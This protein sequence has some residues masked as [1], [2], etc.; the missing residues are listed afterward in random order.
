MYYDKVLVDILYIVYYTRSIN[1]FWTTN[2]AF[3][4]GYN[5]GSSGITDLGNLLEWI[6]QI[7]LVFFQSGDT[8]FLLQKKNTPI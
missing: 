6:S 3:F 7:N 8:N 5:A 2:I 1:I 4:V